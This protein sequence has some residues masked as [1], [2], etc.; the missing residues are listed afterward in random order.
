VVQAKHNLLYRSH[1]DENLRPH[2][3]PRPTLDITSRRL[4]TEMDRR[5]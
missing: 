4:G 5:R 3:L 2:Y 1:G